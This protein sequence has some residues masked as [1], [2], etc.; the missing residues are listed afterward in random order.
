MALFFLHNI[1]GVP[2][3]F[4]LI[5][6]EPET[7]EKSI[8]HLNRKEI[9]FPE[10]LMKMIGSLHCSLSVSDDRKILLKRFASN[11]KKSIDRINWKILSSQSEC[12]MNVISITIYFSSCVIQESQW[13][14]KIIMNS[15]TF[16]VRKKKENSRIIKLSIDL[17][18]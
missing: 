2:V 3:R 16:P 12:H 6:F 1:L 8:W 4:F 7:T 5:Y 15:F 10:L 18:L 13:R 11:Q 17:W 9:V 14:E